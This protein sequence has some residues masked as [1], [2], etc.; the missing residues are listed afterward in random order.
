MRGSHLLSARH[1][2]YSLP[3][4]ACFNNLAVIDMKSRFERKQRP[5]GVDPWRL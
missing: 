4:Q 5:E 1:S 2:G 3:A